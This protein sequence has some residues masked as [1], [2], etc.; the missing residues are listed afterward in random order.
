MKYFSEETRKKMSE[1]A[2]RRCAKPEWIAA[3]KE[4]GTKLDAER[5]KNL[6]ESGMTQKE[7]AD[8]LGVSQKVVCK[9]MKRSNIPARKAAKRDQTGSKNSFWNGGKTQDEFGYVMVQCKE[10]PR[11]SKCG[12][13]VPEHIL[14]AEKKIGRYLT[15]NEVVHHINGRKWDNKPENLSVMTKSEHSKLHWMIRRYNPTNEAVAKTEKQ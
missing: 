4:R 13:Y 12:G 14:I 1:S 2:K 6:Y 7:V 10:H 9:F 11:A 8:I 5:V 3:Q 15:E